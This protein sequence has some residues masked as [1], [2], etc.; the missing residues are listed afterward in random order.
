MTVRSIEALK[1]LQG[2]ARADRLPDASV[3]LPRLA[4]LPPPPAKLVSESAI[5]EWHRLGNFMV[6]CGLLTEA[7]L[8]AFAL[9]CRLHGKLQ[10]TDELN[11]PAMEAYNKA[12]NNF[13]L[14]PVSMSKVKLPADGEKQSNK[15]AHIG[16]RP[17]A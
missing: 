11:I 10:D 5:A 7:S 6:M 4:K 1:A 17:A 9:I 8:P 15:F 13:G 16:V 3:S 14:L 2:T 12:I